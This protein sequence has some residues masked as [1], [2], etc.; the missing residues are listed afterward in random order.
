MSVAIPTT[1]SFLATDGLGGD[2]L[3]VDLFPTAS[4]YTVS[5]ATKILDVIDGFVDEV[6]RDGLIPFRWE[7]GERLIDRDVL[8]A[9]REER[10]RRRESLNEMVRWDQEM[11]LYD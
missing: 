10:I 5:Q 3:D 6:L 4:E 7:N 1:H 9:Y 2:R 11:G 8:L